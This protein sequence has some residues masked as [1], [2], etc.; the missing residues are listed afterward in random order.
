MNSLYDELRNKHNTSSPEEKEFKT[1]LKTTFT[2]IDQKHKDPF[3]SALLK[4]GYTFVLSYEHFEQRKHKEF[5]KNQASFIIKRFF[6]KIMFRKR[7]FKHG[8]MKTLN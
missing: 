7:L 6:K 4:L 3:L 5:K 1:K 8:L 2:Y